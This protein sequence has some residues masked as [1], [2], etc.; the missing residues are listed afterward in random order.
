M[1]T[2]LID[3]PKLADILAFITR[4][5]EDDPARLVLAFKGKI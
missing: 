2:D 5:E 4:H 1:P 3:N